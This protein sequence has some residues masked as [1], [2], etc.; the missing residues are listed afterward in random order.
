MEERVNYILSLRDIFTPKLKA[1][2]K[3]VDT[4][5][6]KTN[7][8]KNSFGGSGGGL[9]ATIAGAFSVAAVAAFG[10]KIIDAGG[11]VE[12]MGVAFE[13]MLGSKARADKLVEEIKSFA[14]RT[15]FELADINQGAKS[16]LAYGVAAD[17]IIP[18]LKVLGDI[19]AGI[20][21]DKLPQLMLAFGQVK[22]MTK[23][24]GN[25][26]RQFSEAGVPLIAALAKQFK[27]TESN[28]VEMVH[29]G[30]VGFKDVEKA[31]T[32]MTTAGGKFFNLMDK[33][34]DTT[35]GKIS[36]LSDA[37][38]NFAA[39]LFDRLKP[40]IDAIVEGLTS[41]L[42]IAGELISGEMFSSKGMTKALLGSQF[43]GQKQEDVAKLQG[44]GFKGQGMFND[45]ETIAS[46]KKTNSLVQSFESAFENS[47]GDA[48]KM[49]D[50][51]QGAE[52]AQGGLAKDLKRGIINADEFG[53][54]NNLF[55]EL[56]DKAT[57][58][59]GGASGLPGEAGA[60]TGGTSSK[61]LSDVESRKSVN[62]N[63][64]INKL[65]E[66]QNIV[67]QNISESATRIK[68]EVSKVL[69]TML[70]D[71]NRLADQ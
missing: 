51:L 47:K 39:T 26:L 70:N 5:D 21:T 48:K 50:F 35:G 59:S 15:P 71:V 31:L 27:T 60:T 61:R 14:L 56:R 10:K 53:V 66:T 64:T 45:K 22:T 55:N 42:R 16:L 38:T 20:G 34:A 23:L 36:N 46:F 12:Q 63:V 43:G 18:T 2:G 62:I 41:I 25:E 1:A 29:D 54:L 6:S 8:L 52:K 49:Q 28:I 69:L 17:D 44:L 32:S 68:D 57:G 33:Q 58:K 3:E 13:T 7:K 11:A 65:I 37:F 19:T 67:A 30:K 4:F 24:T 40:A 9:G